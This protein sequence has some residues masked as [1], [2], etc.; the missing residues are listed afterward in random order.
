[1]LREAERH[2]FQL[3]WYVCECDVRLSVPPMESIIALGLR[4]HRIATV[5]IIHFYSSCNRPISR[6]AFRVSIFIEKKCCNMKS[7]QR[8][9]FWDGSAL[10]RQPAASCGN[11]VIATWQ[12]ARSKRNGPQRV[13]YSPCCSLIKNAQ[14]KLWRNSTLIKMKSALKIKPVKMFQL[15]LLLTSVVPLWWESRMLVC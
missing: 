7:R 3:F 2:G 13:E 11:W 15:L 12:D 9:R 1:M 8:L 5:K 14:Q 6:C 10:T 4:S